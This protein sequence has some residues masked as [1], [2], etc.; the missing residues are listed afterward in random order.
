MLFSFWTDI[1]S[2]LSASVKHK[3]VESIANLYARTLVSL[4]QPAPAKY[5][6]SRRNYVTPWYIMKKVDDKVND[7]YC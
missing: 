1:G 6:D 4:K 7:T 5:N 3:L 2:S